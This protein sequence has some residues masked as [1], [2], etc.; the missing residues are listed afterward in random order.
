MGLIFLVLFNRE[1]YTPMKIS[2]STVYTVFKNILLLWKIK[3]MC[4]C[5]QAVQSLLINIVF[6][7]D[8]VDP[9]NDYNYQLYTLCATPGDNA[10]FFWKF[11]ETQ[12][13]TTKDDKIQL[14]WYWAISQWLSSKLNPVKVCFYCN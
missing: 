4:V 12:D 14:I 6:L 5:M 10:C 3:Y 2:T 1:I 13:P 8:G 11:A 7:S 9:L